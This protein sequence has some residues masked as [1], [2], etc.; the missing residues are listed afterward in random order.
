M[1][2]N[3]RVCALVKRDNKILIIHRFKHGDE[4][5]VVPGGGVEEGETLVEALTREVFE[6]TSLKLIEYELLNEEKIGET[7]HYFYKCELELGEPVIGGPEKES[8]NEDNQ[9]HLEWM[10]MDKLKKINDVY[11]P[12]IGELI[13]IL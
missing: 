8:Q 5:W 11:P 1:R 3:K 9:Y 10:D 12:N 6:E 13:G 7:I 2:T 4:Y